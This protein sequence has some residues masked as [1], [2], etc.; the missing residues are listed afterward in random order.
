MEKLG[1]IKNLRCGCVIIKEGNLISL[2]MNVEDVD[3]PS[4]AVLYRFEFYPLPSYPL[5][6]LYL[7]LFDPLHKDPLKAE[8]L[9]NVAE[10]KELIACLVKQPSLNLHFFNPKGEYISSKE[11]PFFPSQREILEEVIEQ[12][13]S[14][15]SFIPE[16]ERSVDIAL[17]D[18]YAS[19]PI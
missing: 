16:K 3:I 13:E 14:H 15:L 8:C 9:F 7:E 6:R 17:S 1:S 19:Y 4:L 18:F 2:G 5:I 11:I 12:A 10:D